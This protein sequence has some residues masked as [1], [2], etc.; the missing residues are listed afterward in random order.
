[1][2]AHRHLFFAFVKV[3][4]LNLNKLG[5]KKNG[6]M[7]KPLS[8][9]LNPHHC[10]SELVYN[11][12]MTPFFALLLWLTLLPPGLST[13]LTLCHRETEGVHRAG[14]QDS[15]SGVGQRWQDHLT[16]KPRL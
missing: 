1:M 14:G 11:I 7:K 12:S 15:A 13:G 2:I 16:E 8:F 4:Q 3:T 6:N 9:G 5:V 10:A